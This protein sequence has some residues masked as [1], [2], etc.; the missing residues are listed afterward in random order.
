MRRFD[1]RVVWGLLLLAAG[2]LLLLQNFNIVTGALNLIWAFLTGVAAIFFLFTFV[3]NR[4]NWW[5]L[6]PGVIL[7]GLT[8]VITLGVAAPALA[9]A[10]GGPVF[11]GGIGLSFVA[12]YLAS[13]E[14]WWAVI[15]GGVLGTLAVVAAMETVFKRAE[16]RVSTGGIFFIG[17]G[18]TF[19]LVGLLPTPQ[20]RMRWAFIPALVL[21]LMG[22][23]IFAAA[24]QFINYLWPVALILFGLWLI[25]RAFRPRTSE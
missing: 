18:L 25:F 15:P 6:I 22:L 8:A 20:G 9:A 24:E 10:W 12:V 2:V 16:A 13:R 1:L 14:Q 5:A 4:A 3:S 23:L 19:A 7:L 11:L 17:L 21:L